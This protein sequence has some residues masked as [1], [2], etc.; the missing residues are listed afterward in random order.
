MNDARG[1]ASVEVIGFL[2][3][4]LVVALAAF[5]VIASH[6]AHEQAGEAAEA[7]ALVLLQGG[8]QP[9]RRRR[10]RSSG[11]HPPARHDQG[12]TATASRS[13]SARASFSRSRASPTACPAKPTPTRARSRDD[14]PRSRPRV[15]HRAGPAPPRSLRPLRG[16]PAASTR[17]LLPTSRPSPEA[18]AAPASL[19]AHCP[20]P[21][22]R[23]RCRVPARAPVPRRRLAAPPRSRRPSPSRRAAARCHGR[24][25]R[26][27]SRRV[28]PRVAAARGAP[29][30]ASPRR[31][32]PRRTSASRHSRHPLSRRRVRARRRRESRV[33]D[34]LVAPRVG[35]SSSDEPFAVTSAAVLGRPQDVGPM[36]AGVALALRRETR[37]KVASVVVL[38]E[39][40][41][42]LGAGGS[43]GPAGTADRRAARGARPG[44]GDPRT[45]RSGWRSTRGFRNSPRP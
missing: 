23:R 16:R 31:A 39:L 9:A 10:G 33:A 5:T 45:A 4:V 41:R 26:A 38:G 36:A 25:A 19:A 22:S 15:V 1:Q 7:G 30:V 8:E 2:P 20:A 27:A 13:A 43:G 6:T 3:L 18:P 14:R 32:G 21:R 40:P 28:A 11:A 42:D 24:P 29:P 35:V 37:A 12:R 34:A 17:H 44:A